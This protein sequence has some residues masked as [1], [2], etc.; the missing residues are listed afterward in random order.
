MSFLMIR[1]PTRIITAGARKNGPG[2]DRPEIGIP[3]NGRMT[4]TAQNPNHKI[5]KTR[6]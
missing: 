3:I 2:G 5:G 6:L 1:K 4:N